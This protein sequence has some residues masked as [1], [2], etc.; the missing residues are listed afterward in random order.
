MPGT[1][2]F[3]AADGAAILDAS[4]DSTLDDVVSVFAIQDQP[5]RGR[6]IHLGA[7]LDKALRDP[8]GK[9]RYPEPVARML[10]E[11]MMVGAL[12]ARAL[13]FDGR[14]IVQCHGTNEGAISLLVA[15]CST[16][17]DI[18]GYARWDEAMLREITLDSRNPGADAL[19]GRGTFSMTIDQGPDMDQYQG[20]AAI[21]GTTLG[22]CAESYFNQSEQIPTRVRMAIGQIQKGAEPHWR[23]GAIMIQKIAEDE[24]RGDTDDAWATAEALLGT[25]EDAELL[26]PAVSQNRLLFRLF[27][28]E[29]VKVMA[30]SG[31]SANCRCS[32]E[33]LETTLRSFD[34][35]ALEEMADSDGTPG[36]RVITANCEFCGTVYDFP[37]DELKA[38]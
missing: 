17:G 13:K 34:R 20:V 24:L 29:G 26:D 32:R 23:G 36:D 2:D 4:L 38:A 21:Q 30:Q 15:D 18:R 3:S 28:D 1:A 25:V 6:A 37:L 8:D 16:N 14:I 22:E 9:A 11:A 33:R 31:V 35:A 12:V 27:H 10:G 5:V 7:A 19:L